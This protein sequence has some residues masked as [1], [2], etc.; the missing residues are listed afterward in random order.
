M[1]AIRVTLYCEQTATVDVEASEDATDAELT[2]LALQRLDESGG[3]EWVTTSGW[4]EER[5]V[6]A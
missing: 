1:A 3:A 5:R 6:I 2:R 4:V